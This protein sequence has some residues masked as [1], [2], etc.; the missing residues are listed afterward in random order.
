MK[1]INSKF[2]FNV[3]QEI[4]AAC[5]AC[6]ARIYSKIECFS[7]GQ[8]KVGRS[9]SSPLGNAA[10]L[11]RPSPDDDLV[12]IRSLTPSETQYNAMKDAISNSFP[13]YEFS[14]I[15]PEHFQRI[16]TPEQARSTISWNLSSFLPD[17][18]ALSQDLWN[19][20]E[21]EISPAFCDIYS[22]EPDCADVFTE[23]G[24]LWAKIFLFVNEKQRKV[25][26]FHIREGAQGFESESDD[27]PYGYE[28]NI[29][30]NRYGF[31][32]F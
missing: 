11:R 28:T 7:F 23:N 15:L 21:N 14:G 6:D 26:L 25:I 22:Y 9:S 20:I 29:I 31:G 27:D 8:E 24:A 2:L 10:S 32:V 13:D 30:E 1:W 3:N 17:N 5:S 18:E 16:V 12:R 4:S 19:A